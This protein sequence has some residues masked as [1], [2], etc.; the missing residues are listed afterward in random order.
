MHDERLRVCHPLTYIIN[1]GEKKNLFKE[2]NECHDIDSSDND[3]DDYYNYKDDKEERKGPYQPL[4]TERVESIRN[5]DD[6]DILRLICNPPFVSSRIEDSFSVKMGRRI[7]KHIRCNRYGYWLKTKDDDPFDERLLHKIHPYIDDYLQTSL[8]N[9]E[10]IK[11]K[12]SVK[13]ERGRTVLHELVLR[14]I[15]NPF[16]NRSDV[17]EMNTERIG[18]E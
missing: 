13:N 17:K 12:C 15:K 6:M 2:K 9:F 5:D 7:N 11:R 10:Q 14:Y 8:Q 3:E 18:K 1:K 16:D 4:E